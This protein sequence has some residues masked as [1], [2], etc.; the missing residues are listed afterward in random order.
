[1]ERVAIIRIEP[2]CT[3]AVHLGFQVL[4]GFTNENQPYLAIHEDT[5]KPIIETRV[6]AYAGNEPFRDT[7][8]YV[9]AYIACC[10]FKGRPYFV[11]QLVERAGTH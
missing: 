8:K 2:D 3:I 1:M 6:R 7:A 5:S 10:M 9:H 4:E 11:F